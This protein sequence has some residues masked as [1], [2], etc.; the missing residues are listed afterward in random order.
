MF[1]FHVIGSGQFES[2]LVKDVESG[3]DA[4]GME[5]IFFRHSAVTGIEPTSSPV[6][7]NKV[8]PRAS[9]VCHNMAFLCKRANGSHMENTVLYLSCY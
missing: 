8:S 7:W 9:P 4:E 3:R 2:A 5:P 6:A 1:S